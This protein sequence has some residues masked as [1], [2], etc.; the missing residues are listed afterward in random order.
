MQLEDEEINEKTKVAVYHAE[1]CGV[2]L[3]NVMSPFPNYE[4]CG[5][6][7][8]IVYFALSLS[9]KALRVF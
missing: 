7:R 1:A 5:L 9:S 2:Q 8:E 3:G 6:E 4:A